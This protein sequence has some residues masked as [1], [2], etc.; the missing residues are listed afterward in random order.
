MKNNNPNKIQLYL[1]E[2]LYRAYI[3]MQLPQ[4][5]LNFE[6]E[7]LI[8]TFA[9]ELKELLLEISEN[10]Q[11]LSNDLEQVNI[12]QALRRNFH[13]LKG[14]GRMLGFNSVSE[15]AWTVETILNIRLDQQ[16]SW[17]QLV[18]EYVELISRI[19]RYIIV[20]SLIVKQ[21]IQLDVKPLLLLGR[22]LEHSNIIDQSL[23]PLL[24]INAHLTQL[25]LDFRIECHCLSDSNSLSAA[26][27]IE[28]TQIWDNEVL[29][30][31]YAESS[32]QL[33]SLQ[34]MLDKSNQQ[35]QVDTLARVVHS[36]RGSSAIVGLEK[37]EVLSQSFEKIIQRNPSLD[38]NN[39][40]LQALT[41]QYI[42]LIKYYLESLQT[43]GDNVTRQQQFQAL[44]HTFLIALRDFSEQIT[45]NDPNLDPQELLKKIVDLGVEDVFLIDTFVQDGISNLFSST[46]T[47]ERSSLL[48]QQ[49]SSIAKFAIKVDFDLLQKISEILSSIHFNIVRE[50]NSIAYSNVH[51]VLQQGHE[52]L[53]EIFDELAIGQFAQNNEVSQQLLGDLKQLNHEYFSFSNQS[54]CISTIEQESEVSARS[55]DETIL[56]LLN[57][58][59]ALK[60]S[61]KA[62]Q[63]LDREV[64]GFFVEEAEEILSQIEDLFNT[65]LEYQEDATCIQKIM[66]QLHTLKGGAYMLQADYFANLIHELES[67]YLQLI[68]EQQIDIK[69]F[70]I[71]IKAL[72]QDLVRRV[73]I[74]K[75]E[76]VDYPIEQASRL[77]QSLIELGYLNLKG[78]DSKLN[79]VHSMQNDITHHMSS[80]FSIHSTLSADLETNL[81]DLVT[82]H[83]NSSK[84]DSSSIQQNSHQNEPSN[85]NESVLPPPMSGNLQKFVQS[86]VANETLSVSTAVIEA[87]LNLIG[88]DLIQRSQVEVELKSYRS[89]L[90]EMDQTIQRLTSQLR[91][92][93]GEL[94]SQIL[95]QRRSHNSAEHGF[96]P[97]EMDQYSSLNQLSKSISE[98]TSDLLD[99]RNSLHEKL[100]SAESI[101]IQQAR[102]QNNIQHS[103]M[104]TRVVP[105]KTIQMRLERL[106][107]QLSMNL[108]KSVQLQIEHADIEL[109]RSILEKLITSLEHILRNAIDHGIESA[110]QRLK[111]NKPEQA[112]MQLTLVNHHNELS[113]LIKDDGRGIDSQEIK[114]KAVEFGWLN[115]EREYSETELLQLIFRPGFTTAAKL[116][117]VSGRGVGLDVVKSEIQALGGHVHVTSERGQG[118]CFE[119]RIPKSSIITEALMVKVADQFFALPL[120]QI[121]RVEMIDRHD[122]NHAKQQS[123]LL[124]VHE[125]SYQLNDLADF[126]LLNQNIKRNSPYSETQKVPVILVNMHQSQPVALFVDEV[127]GT[128][129]QIIVKQTGRL[130]H[131]IDY[132]SGVTIMG[133][134]EICPILNVNR[135]VQYLTQQDWSVHPESKLSNLKHDNEAP[136]ILV[137]DDSVTVRKVTSKLLERYGYQIVTATDGIEALEY[138]QHSTPALMLIDVEMPRMD[139]FEVMQW[140]RN[141][142]H[143]QNLPVVMITSRV[144]DKHKQ[145]ALELGV[146]AYMG[147]PFQEAVLIEQINQLLKHD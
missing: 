113:I 128:N 135:V 141:Q 94:E 110:E 50:P 36:L 81:S 42:D 7:E 96:D 88:E 57:I 129:S 146:S 14:S 126:V 82:T 142:P 28:N 61:A 123:Q 6:D 119:I 18:L 144:G 112:V 124:R 90:V 80:D 60:D 63:G 65:W 107:K 138:L 1:S 118:T 46:R 102:I 104:R 43:T 17:S 103:L 67:V 22:Q 76:S 15:L 140:L 47:T 48:S 21:A 92:M 122:L 32:E 49:L 20:P 27:T 58:D 98:S 71:L 91:R 100:Q 29:Q 11:V 10:F 8:T 97:L 9:E 99:I 72:Q 127:L 74:I 34:D 52:K 51:R 56:T 33:K 19:Y 114:Q 93:E 44:E 12:W 111:L 137:V 70:I 83:N 132:L 23:H 139:G 116:T 85:A 134:G 79:L 120:H 121:Q 84:F 5:E 24:A 13:T 4:D 109:D 54:N 66:R 108:N 101:L 133:S 30:S 130:I 53:L 68:S 86:A 38:A 45:Q 77:I 131:Q 59:Y 89:N 125:A 37:I 2:A 143:L 136:T 145:H 75:T 106:C 115:T 95:L 73:N 69:S 105:F 117:T 40:Q 41:T 87:T 147:K 64:S 31:F 39:K 25:D 16:R 3:D 26:A 78:S 62:K 35:F 55:L